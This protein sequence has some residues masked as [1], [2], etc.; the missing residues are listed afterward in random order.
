Y[1]FPD[2]RKGEI[3]VNMKKQDQKLQ[4]TVIDDGVG[5]PDDFDWKN[6]KSLG[7][8]LVRTLVENQLDGSIDFDNTNGTKFT[9]K[10]NI[11]T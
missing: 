7:L 6:S 10:F 11:E 2:E 5:I 3:N 4:L 1:A 8:K 9:I